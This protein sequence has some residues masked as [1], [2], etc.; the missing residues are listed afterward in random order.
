MTGSPERVQLTAASDKLSSATKPQVEF[1]VRE[2]M[3]A[4]MDIDQAAERLPSRPK[5]FARPAEKQMMH[6][7]VGH[8]I[9]KDASQK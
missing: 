2:V 7:K 1:D 3:T 4:D 9:H 6:Y 8:D 5:I